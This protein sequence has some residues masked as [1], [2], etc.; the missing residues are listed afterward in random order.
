MN[1]LGYRTHGTWGSN[2][3]SKDTVQ[4]LLGNRF[5]LGELPDGNGGWVPGKHSA[6]IP[7]EVW[8]QAQ[9]ARIRQRRNPQTI[10]GHAWVHVLGGGLL[11]CGVCWMQG[12]SSALHVAKSRKTEDTAYYACYGRFQGYPCPQPSVPDRR[13][14]AQ[15]DSFFAAFVLP[16]AE[17]Q[18]LLDLYEQEQQQ[19]LPELQQGPTVVQR[20][21]QL[22][23]R[24]ERQRHL[25]E[26][27]DWTRE[28]YLEARQAVLAELAE[29]ETAVPL[30]E[31]THDAASLSRLCDY[32]RELGTA[33]REA[34]KPN[35]RL[36]VRTLFEQ[37]WVVGD[38]IIAA[39]PVVQFAPFSR[40][41]RNL[42]GEDPDQRY[43][44]ASGIIWEL[45]E[46][47]LA[48]EQVGNAA[49][50]MAHDLDDHGQSV[51]TPAMVSHGVQTSGPDGERSSESVPPASPVLSAVRDLPQ[52]LFYLLPQA[53]PPWPNA[54]PTTT[55]RQYV[56]PGHPHIHLPSCSLLSASRSLH[57]SALVSPISP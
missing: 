5:Y 41:I 3:F 40:L 14:E 24:L 51:L 15:L 21:T 30:T 7:E 39:K 53:L 43:F 19:A 22:E 52:G 13:L 49:K 38:R 20:R 57:T 6:L 23:A 1:D 44:L 34:D 2:P 27:G 42:N 12:R 50:E 55:G 48:A 56:G 25:Y 10:P 54:Q 32:V 26:F 33:W 45:E 4:H 11:R 29:L 9:R 37:L 8:D 31:Q 36:L 35:K 18:R 16:P 46:M 28:S 47:E 17:Q